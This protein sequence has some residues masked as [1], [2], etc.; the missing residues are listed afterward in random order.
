MFGNTLVGKVKNVLT[1]SEYKILKQLSFWSLSSKNYGVEKDYKTW[2][3]NTLDQWAEQLDTSVSTVRRTI[4]SLKEKGFISAQHL[5]PNKR[6]R[7]LYYSVNFEAIV[8]FLSEQKRPKNIEEKIVPSAHFS[9]TAKQAFEQMGEQMDEQM[10]NNIQDQDQI[11]KSNKSEVPPNISSDKTAS[12][13]NERNTPTTTT[14]QDMIKIFRREFPKVKITLTL[15]LCRNLVAAFRTKFDS[16]LKT[17]KRYLELIKTSTFITSEKFTLSLFWI[18]K[19]LT[20]DRIRNGELG[21]DSGKL[22]V[23]YDEIERKAW[24]HVDSVNES[25][26]CKLFRRKIVEII[27]PAAYT[28]WFTKTV[29]TFK[30]NRFCLKTESSFMRDYIATN[31]ANKL[32][33][34]EVI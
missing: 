25:K 33:I 4:K 12:T 29:L 1:S 5:S 23:D 14:V 28:A 27:S 3:Y 9:N 19:F 31:F 15:Q 6:N 16:N 11:N 13:S 17:W 26:E 2:I 30:E 10:Y 21:V 22:S 24:N 7:T 18:I 8:Q 34:A 32:G 20:I